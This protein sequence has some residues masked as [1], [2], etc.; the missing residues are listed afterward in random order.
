MSCTI[1]I[2]HYES[3]AYLR[4]CVRQVLKYAREDIRQYIIIADQSFNVGVKNT[5]YMEFG[6]IKDLTIMNI[7]KCGSGY[8]IDHVIREGVHTDYI[9]NIDVDTMAIHPNWL[10]VP[11]KL[12]EEYDFSF[13]SVHAEIEAAYSHMGEF[14]CLSQYFRVGKTED[15]KQLSLNG[16]F[17]RNDSRK[18][19]TYKNNEWEGWSDDSVIA[20]WWEDKYTDNSKLALGVPDYLG[21]AP[22]EGRYGRYTDDLVFHF[23]LSYNWKM[24]GNKEASLGKDFLAWMERMEREGLTEEMLSEMLSLRIPLER[25]LPRQVWDGK[26][27][28]SS[29]STEQLN[30]RIEELKNEDS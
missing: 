3:L 9:C 23:G 16:G 5:I 17:S 19:L 21:V 24:V 10:Y 12:I 18:L 27:K 22:L 14:F 29:L 4:A 8:S 1:I 7:P 20:H 26:T 28:T 11:I 15:Y 25:P 13:V 30:N 2:F 6:M